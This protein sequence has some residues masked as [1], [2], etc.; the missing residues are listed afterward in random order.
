MKKPLP[1]KPDNKEIFELLKGTG[2]ENQDKQLIYSILC[3][4]WKDPEVQ[5]V[6]LYGSYARLEQKP[7][8]DIDIAV[9]TGFS[10]SS[11]KQKERI[12]SFSSKKYDVQVFSDLPLPAKFQI[13][14]NGIPLFIRDTN[15]QRNLVRSVILTYMDCESMRN[16]WKIRI[17]G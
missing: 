7:Y 13:F 16:R 15:Y 9:I 2:L 1:N 12:G 8:S 10:K 14:T 4:L 17:L 6:Y 5:A 11:R 3:E